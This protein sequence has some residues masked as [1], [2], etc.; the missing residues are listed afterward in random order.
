M[1]DLDTRLLA[2]H[3]SGDLHALVT[4]YQTAADGAETED[5]RGFYLTH[6]HVFALEIGHP[7]TACLRAALIAMGRET[8]L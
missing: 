2:A 6:A 4:L 1:S 7:D 3:A 5:A 8:P